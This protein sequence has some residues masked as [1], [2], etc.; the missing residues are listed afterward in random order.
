MICHIC[1]EL[2]V[3]GFS[4]VSCR[5]CCFAWYMIVNVASSDILRTRKNN[6]S[7]YEYVKTDSQEV[8]DRCGNEHYSRNQET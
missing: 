6:L 8:I 7:D 3:P 2:N 4:N 1:I 5:I